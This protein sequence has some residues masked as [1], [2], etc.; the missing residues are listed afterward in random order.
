MPIATMPIA[1]TNICL[2]KQDSWP[3]VNL[4]S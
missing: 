1:T 2:T 4:K 3:Y